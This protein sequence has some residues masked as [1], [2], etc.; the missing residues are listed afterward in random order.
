MSAMVRVRSAA[1]S[2]YPPT[3]LGSSPRTRVFS[4]RA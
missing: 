3:P 4:F 2:T 1:V